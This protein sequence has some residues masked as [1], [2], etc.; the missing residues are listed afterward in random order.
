MSDTIVGLLTAFK[1]GFI[2][3]LS[4]KFLWVKY[5][6]EVDMTELVIPDSWPHSKRDYLELC[7][8]NAEIMQL[9]PMMDKF[10]KLLKDA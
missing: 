9:G 8:H 5:R 4:L 6:S 1:R 10:R 3:G 2:D 7:L